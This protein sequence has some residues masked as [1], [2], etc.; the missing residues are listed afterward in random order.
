MTSIIYSLSLGF[1]LFLIVCY[2]IEIESILYLQQSSMGSSLQYSV[3]TAGMLKPS[4]LEP[5]LKE[6]ESFIVG[7][8]FASFEM[9]SA[10]LINA[11]KCSY[12]DKARLNE[13]ELSVYG[14]TPSVFDA[15]YSE[16]LEI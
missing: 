8:S 5:V 16:Y 14:V 4:T 6:Y 15:T 1:I 2:N 13:E 3:A 11:T 9:K 7:F 10:N 12:S